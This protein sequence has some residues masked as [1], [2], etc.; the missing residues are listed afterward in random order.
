[1]ECFATCESSVHACRILRKSSTALYPKETSE[2]LHQT[3]EKERRIYFTF[4]KGFI[5]HDWAYHCCKDSTKTTQLTLDLTSIMLR[6]NC[7]G[8]FRDPRSSLDMSNFA[9]SPSTGGTKQLANAFLKSTFKTNRL[10]KIA[11][12]PKV[13]PYGG[14]V[15][16]TKSG[17]FLEQG[18][19]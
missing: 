2:I 19:K 11:A 7:V 14:G 1:M 10:R 18:R 12:H 13:M 15:E 9:S 6:S 17:L 3:T 8:T 4:R 16:F 5:L